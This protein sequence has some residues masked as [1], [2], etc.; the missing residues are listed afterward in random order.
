VHGGG[1]LLSAAEMTFLV[2]GGTLVPRYLTAR[3][4]PWIRVLLGDLDGFVGRTAGELDA[5]LP[6]RSRAL[7][8][9]HGVGPRTIL[10]VCRVLGA[11]WRR[12]VDAVKPPTTVRRAVFD[13]A[14]R[15]PV[16]DRVRALAEAAKELEVR[17]EEVER[18]LYADLPSARKI[19]APDEAPS[20]RRVAELYNLRLV[21]GLLLRAE[22]ATV[23][24]R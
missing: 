19:M 6:E 17:A 14:A 18:A 23:E 8:L 2:R 11:F 13:A 24:V 4:E 20:P 21:Q 12:R 10:G 22:V 9:D 15:L 1:S 7:A 16:P 3:D 5:E